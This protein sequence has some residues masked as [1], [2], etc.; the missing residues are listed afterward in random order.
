MKLKDNQWANIGNLSVIILNTPISGK[1]NRLLKIVADKTLPIR[2][3]FEREFEEALIEA[4][5]P[6][7]GSE[8]WLEVNIAISN[9]FAKGETELDIP[10]FKAEWF[11]EV[12]F[13]PGHYDLLSPILT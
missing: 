3:Q 2:T 12:K 8:K 10:E 11:D 13:Q 6:A 9:S 5:S 1:L 7:F 4:D